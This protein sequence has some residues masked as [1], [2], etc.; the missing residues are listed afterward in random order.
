MSFYSWQNVKNFYQ[1]HCNNNKDLLNRISEI[2]LTDYNND[3]IKPLDEIKN[4]DIIESQNQFQEL[5]DLYRSNKLKCLRLGNV[6]SYFLINYYFKY[7][8]P[9]HLFRNDDLDFNMRH[10]A[11]LYYKNIEDKKNISDWWCYNTIKFLLKST[12]ISAYCF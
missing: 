7:K 2:P 11:G 3:N 10:N 8:L 6:E 12:I 1:Y 9:S 4:K 5:L